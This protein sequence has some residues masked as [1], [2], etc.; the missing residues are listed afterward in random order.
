MKDLPRSPLAYNLIALLGYVLAVIFRLW[1]FSAFVCA[2]TL[3]YL[4][5]SAKQYLGIIIA[6][7][8]YAVLLYFWFGRVSLT[9][10]TSY[11]IAFMVICLIYW[12]LTLARPTAK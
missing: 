12:G 1:G 6:D 10:L 2:L 8:A 7:I 9:E 4:G 11:S 3:Y 5:A